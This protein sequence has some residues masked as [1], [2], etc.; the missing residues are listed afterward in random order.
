MAGRN[1][2]QIDYRR[3]LNFRIFTSIAPCNTIHSLGVSLKRHS[4]K[5]II[6]VTS[7]T[8]TTAQNFRYYLLSFVSFLISF[9][10]FIG[11]KLAIVAVAIGIALL[12]EKYIDDF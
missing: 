11:L 12:A 10:G 1:K 5:F 7:K 8:N 4:K 2:L 3:W 9:I 6:N